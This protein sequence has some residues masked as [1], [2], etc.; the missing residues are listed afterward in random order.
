MPFDVASDV[1]TGGGVRHNGCGADMVLKKNQKTKKHLQARFQEGQSV[2]TQALCKGTEPTYIAATINK[3]K[4]AESV[5]TRA[6]L[7]H[8]KADCGMGGLRK[9][10]ELEHSHGKAS[11]RQHCT[12]KWRH[13]WLRDVFCYRIPAPSVLREDTPRIQRKEF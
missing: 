5:I 7:Q 8:C 2:D 11:Q 10:N 9:C 3:C 6:G 1:E 12:L 4:Q 13:I